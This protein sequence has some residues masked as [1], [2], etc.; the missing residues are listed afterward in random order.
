MATTTSPARKPDALTGPPTDSSGK[1]WPIGL[2]IAAIV[3]FILYWKILPS[4]SQDV[5]TF[6][7]QWL[8]VSAVNEAVIWVIFALGLNIVVGYAGLLDLGY[9]AFWAIGGYCAGWIMSPFFD[10]VNVNFLGHAQPGLTGGIHVNFWLVLPLAG[11]FCALWG[12]IIGAPTSS[13]RSSATASTCSASTSPTATRASPRSTR[14][15]PGRSA[16]SPASRP[17]S[18]C[19]RPTCRSSSSSTAC[20][21]R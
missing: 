18:A 8:S 10:A 9:V 2:T 16:T 4:S 17:S 13:R 1:K 14:S 3:I 15:R 7:R 11:L 20:S 5:Q 21:R 12:V 19:G 6:F